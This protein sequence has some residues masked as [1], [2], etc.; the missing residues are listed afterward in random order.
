ME[1]GPFSGNKADVAVSAS[2]INGCPAENFGSVTV[3]FHHLEAERAI[4]P[5]MEVLADC[6]SR[7]FSTNCCG[8]SIPWSA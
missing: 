4:E 5:T 7:L 6:R 3:G 2:E 1:A 8:T